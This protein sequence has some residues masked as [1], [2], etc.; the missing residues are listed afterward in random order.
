MIDLDLLLDYHY[1]A[2]DRL[3]DAVAPLTPADYVADRGNSFPSIRDTVVPLYS[4]EWVWYSRW[5]G[6]SPSAQRAAAE[7]PDVPS[8]RAAWLDLEREVRA[9]VGGLDADA[10]ARVFDYHAFS[11]QPLRSVFWHT[12]QHLVN[13]GSYHRGQL[14]TLL[15]QIGAA[16]P[17]SMDLIAFYRE[18][19]L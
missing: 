13:H 11:G 3:I 18:R 4:S 5:R 17:K 12:L 14:T 6:Q 16:P 2:R 8:V 19:G 7:Y 9:H 1:W 15:R 10:R